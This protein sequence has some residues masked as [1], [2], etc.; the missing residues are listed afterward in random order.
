[1]KKPKSGSSSTENDKGFN[2]SDYYRQ[3]QEIDDA[4]TEEIRD[5]ISGVKKEPETEEIEKLLKGS[6]KEKPEDDQLDQDDLGVSDLNEPGPIMDKDSFSEAVMSE[7]AAPATGLGSLEVSDQYIYDRAKDKKHGMLSSPGNRV[8]RIRRLRRRTK[9]KLYKISILIFVILVLGVGYVQLENFLPT[10]VSLYEQARAAHKEKDYKKAVE[11]YQKFIKENPNDSNA[12][13]ARYSLA[14]SYELLGDFKNAISEYNNVIKSATEDELAALSQYTVANLYINLE[15]NNKAREYLNNLIENFPKNLYV[16][17]G[18]PQK[19][20]ALTLENEGK[21]GEAISY[22]HLILD[23]EGFQ[24][25]GEIKFK[26]GRCFEILGNSN[27]ARKAYLDLVRDPLTQ[28]EWR[29]KAQQ[30]LNR[31]YQSDLITATNRMVEE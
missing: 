1:M 4:L 25:N 9:R 23:L 22:Y 20:F 11:L 29:Q 31:L 28:E 24:D 13:K 18:K 30:E 12:V 3:F 16:R 8:R 19:L 2:E 7:P 17:K 27:S 10:R 6:L 26:I 21:W 5:E 15:D 14:G